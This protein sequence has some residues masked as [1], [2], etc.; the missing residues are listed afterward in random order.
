MAIIRQVDVATTVTP[1][2]TVSLEKEATPFARA[3]AQYL[4]PT[5]TIRSEYAGDHVYAPYGETQ[6]SWIIPLLLLGLIW[7]ALRKR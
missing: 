2:F 3:F 4:K 7:G 5:F 1:K 6:G